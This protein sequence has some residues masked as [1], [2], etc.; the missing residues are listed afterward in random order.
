MAVPVDP[1]AADLEV[2]ANPAPPPAPVPAVTDQAPSALPAPP[3]QLEGA[4]SG[5]QEQLNE[6]FHSFVHYFVFIQV[7]NLHRFCIV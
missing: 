4:V 5:Q 6:V 2:L 7:S 3:A 1:A